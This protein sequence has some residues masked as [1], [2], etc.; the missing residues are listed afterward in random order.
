MIQ[1][2]EEDFKK[3]RM[4][5][6]QILAAKR[7]VMRDKDT[8]YANI[9]TNIVRSNSQGDAERSKPSLLFTIAPAKKRSS[10]LDLVYKQLAEVTRT[11]TEGFKDP[12]QEKYKELLEDL[13]VFKQRMNIK[14]Y[15][16]EEKE[17]EK[18]MKEYRDRPWQDVKKTRK[19]TNPLL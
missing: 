11:Y 7:Q 10:S 14:N 13:R 19:N 6:D 1:V 3:K 17:K 2:F 8:L 16:K 15:V 4:K 9:Q 12:I 5:F 18:E